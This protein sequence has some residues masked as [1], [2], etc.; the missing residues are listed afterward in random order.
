[1]SQKAKFTFG[2]KVEKENPQYR[3]SFTTFRVLRSAVIPAPSLQ[4]MGTDEGIVNNLP[5]GICVQCHCAGL[6][7]HRAYKRQSGVIQAAACM[8]ERIPAAGRWEPPTD[9]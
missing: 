8:D 7:S 9:F 2:K 4:V 6:H 1:M 5:Y 3:L